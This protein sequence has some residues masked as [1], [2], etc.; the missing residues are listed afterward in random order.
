MFGNILKPVFIPAL[1][2]DLAAVR[3]L[4]ASSDAPVFFDSLGLLVLRK[5]RK[6]LREKELHLVTLVARVGEVLR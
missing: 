4:P 6:I 2:R 3:L 5:R 1:I